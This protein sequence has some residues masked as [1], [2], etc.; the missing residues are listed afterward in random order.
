MR[1]TDS[2]S[3]TFFAQKFTFEE[4]TAI[5]KLSNMWSMQQLHAA[6]KSTLT[7]THS[8]HQLCSGLT[9][10]QIMA[11]AGKDITLFDKAKLFA[12]FDNLARRPDVIFA[13]EALILD[14]PT[15]AYL[16]AAR[17]RRIAAQYESEEE[18]AVIESEFDAYLEYRRDPTVIGK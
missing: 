15:V 1:Y 11:L 14:G 17:E 9:D 10:I 2:P 3:R 18:V 13:R 12:T 5:I 8:P 7:A 6:T 4:W 16:A